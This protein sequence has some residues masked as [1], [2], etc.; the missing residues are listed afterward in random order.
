MDRPPP[1]PGVG[2]DFAGA[3]GCVGRKSDFGWALGRFRGRGILSEKVGGWLC[4]GGKE[5]VSSSGV[6]ECVS[7]E[8]SSSFSVF[9]RPPMGKK[10]E[11]NPWPRWHDISLEDYADAFCLPHAQ[12]FAPGHEETPYIWGRREG[13]AAICHC[14]SIC[15]CSGSKTISPETGWWARWG[16]HPTPDQ[17][18]SPP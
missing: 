15:Q 17:G 7:L 8:W 3:P 13:S 2:S 10:A 14:S 12:A 11:G 16:E 5:S 1:P 9:D 18:G 4:A 6:S